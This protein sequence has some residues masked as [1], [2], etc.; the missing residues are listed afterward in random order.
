VPVHPLRLARATAEAELVTALAEL[1][2]SLG[3][4]REFAPEVLT[5]AETAVARTALPSADRTDIPFLTIDPEGST[6]LD[7]ALALERGAEGLVVHYAIADL[8]AYVVPG[9]EIDRAARERGT[10]IYAADG[11]IPLHPVA[12][13]EHAASLLPDQVRG[14]FVWTFQLDARGEVASTSLERAR[15]RSRRQLSYEQADAELAAGSGASI[16]TLRL[17][18]ELGE[19]RLALEAERGGASL[20]TPEILV[21]HDGE[22]YAL[23]RR[24]LH[25][26]ERANAQL[27]LLTGMA[28]A[29]IMLEGGVG[30]LRTMPPADDESVEHFR[31][32]TRALGRP[33]PAEQPYGAYLRELD[34]EQ[35]R[36]LAILHAAASLFRGASYTVFDGSSPEETLQAAIAAPYT[37]VTA[38]LRRL[39]DRF[40]LLTCEAL[41]RGER[42]AVW[43]LEGLPELPGIMGRAASAAGRL[44]RLTLDLV[45]AA[46]LAPRVG[47]EFDAVVVRA[48]GSGGRIQLTDP[49]VEAEFTGD[50]TPGESLR[51]RLARADVATGTLEFTRA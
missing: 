22:R 25:P 11:R 9:G 40:S 47:E 43:V 16:D 39:V 26:I 37:H 23:E 51:V 5:E 49:D 48:N 36:D 35:P 38:P 6:D 41:V 8:P 24:A 31:R 7:Q 2:A 20:S 29:Q 34:G 15:V 14:A 18:L 21:T 17:L 45:E 10:T 27:S 33:W 32:Q 13:S 19:L 12:I 44:D 1:P 3:L 50:V 4:E 28:A 30:I 42:P 46:V